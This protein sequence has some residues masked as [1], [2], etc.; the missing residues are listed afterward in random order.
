[1]TDLDFSRRVLLQR[2]SHS[3]LKLAEW[4]LATEEELEELG[5]EYR[6]I[7]DALVVLW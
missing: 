3:F 6:I 5:R 1:M 4:R 2:V 7:E